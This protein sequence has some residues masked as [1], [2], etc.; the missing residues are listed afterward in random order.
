MAKQAYWELL[1]DPRWQ[2]KRLE[3]MER[4]DFKCE[5]CGADGKTLNVH[6]K[7]YRKDASPW[8]YSDRELQCLCGDCH[9]T[10]HD[11]KSRLEDVLTIVGIETVVGFADAL[12]CASLLD[13]VCQESWQISIRSAEHARG[14]LMF[15]KNSA[16]VNEVR[17][18]TAAQTLTDADV[19]KLRDQGI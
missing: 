19:L 3:I 15:F 10:Y 8:E 13:G 2:R 1:R 7:R 16:S 11:W 6:H 9:Q 12:L 5:V 14:F 17:A 4:A 18:L